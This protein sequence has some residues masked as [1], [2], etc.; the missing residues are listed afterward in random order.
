MNGLRTPGCEP[1]RLR[2]AVPTLTPL[3]DGY[4]SV[5]GTARNINEFSRFG[6]TLLSVRREKWRIAYSRARPGGISARRGRR[7]ISRAEV[8]Q[9]S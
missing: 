9:I 4:L 6:K 1:R 5:F 7:K 2:F 3:S 8:T